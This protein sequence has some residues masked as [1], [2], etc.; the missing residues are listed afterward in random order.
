MIE[1]TPTQNERY[2]QLVSGINQMYYSE[3]EPLE[4]IE[5][6]KLTSF[7]FDQLQ[8]VNTVWRIAKNAQD[9]QTVQEVEEHEQQLYRDLDSWE[10]IDKDGWSFK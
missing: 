8:D 4:R 10:R 6:L 1:G 3:P 2:A 7:I 5:Q 9:W